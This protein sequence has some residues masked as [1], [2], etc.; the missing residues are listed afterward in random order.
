MQCVGDL[1]DEYLM[2]WFRDGNRSVWEVLEMDLDSVGDLGRR[3][4]VEIGKKGF[5]VR[6]CGRE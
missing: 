5:R 3:V 6:V 4:F 1:G 2:E